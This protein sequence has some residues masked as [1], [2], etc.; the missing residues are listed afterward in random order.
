[1]FWFF[2]EIMPIQPLDFNQNKKET[3]CENFGVFN[4]VWTKIGGW[5]G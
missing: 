5:I 3:Q 4:K 1:M 2:L